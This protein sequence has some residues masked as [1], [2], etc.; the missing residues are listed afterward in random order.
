MGVIDWGFRSVHL[1]TT[2]SDVSQDRVG[3]RNSQV[4]RFWK[5]HSDLKF[6]KKPFPKLSD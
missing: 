5:I 1:A 2:S 4:I 6:L 3:K